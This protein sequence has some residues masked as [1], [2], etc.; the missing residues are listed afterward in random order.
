M[1]NWTPN[2]GEGEGPLYRSIAKQLAG[3]IARGELMPGTRL[4]T[5]RDLALRLRISVQTVSQAYAEVERQGLVSGEV[6]R[7][8]FVLPPPGELEP[9]FIM[10]RRSA[11]VID[12][13]INRP[14][15]DEIH[16]IRI[17]EGLGRLAQGDP[18]AMLVCRPIGG[19][20]EH[21]KAGARWLERRGLAVPAD[22]V[23]LTNGATHGMLVALGSVTQ[24]GDLV[25]TEALV[26]HSVI[27]LASLLSL[28]LEGLPLDREGIVPDAFEAAC[29]RGDVKAL[30]VTPTLS[31]PTVALMSTAR[32][33]QIATIARRHD[34][35]VIEDDVYGWLVPD[36][37][38]ALASFLPEATCYVTSF[39]K[40]IVSGLRTGY[41]AAPGG[42][43]GR[44]TRRIRVTAWMAT[45]LVAELATRWVGD[46]TADELITWQQHALA[47]RQAVVREVLGGLQVTQ[48]PGAP[49]AW[50]ELPEPWRPEVLAAEARLKHV[51]VTPADPF[52]TD[53]PAAP[54]G[55]RI[56]VGPPHSLAQLRHGLTTLAELL[57]QEPEPF[58]LPI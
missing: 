5:Q 8:T 28:R 43:V 12:L 3:A 11:D 52:A 16:R 25:L 32:R 29:A 30:C 40:A 58:Y 2:L 22:R 50:L 47:A 23:L 9:R 24:P 14:V 42:L 48:H 27:G 57:R 4:P 51:A 6:G 13:S 45:P 39:T 7:G 55:I 17:R 35:C 46:G 37:P 15:Y 1:S 20:E 38:P 10:D 36:G 53:R 18:S 56:S 31:N 54:R 44:L 41:L 26:D 49:H 19:M 21:K 33:Q 34:V